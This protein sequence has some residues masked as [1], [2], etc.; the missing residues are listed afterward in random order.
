MTISQLVMLHLISGR[1]LVKAKVRGV[2][3]ETCFNLM[4][5][6]VVRKTVTV[7]VNDKS[8]L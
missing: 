5:P 4:R 1:R 2:E 6:R 3:L 7:T 8:G